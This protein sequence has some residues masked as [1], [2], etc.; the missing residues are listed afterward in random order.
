MSNS[1]HHLPLEQRTVTRVH[2]GKLVTESLLDAITD[3]QALAARFGDPSRS[4]ADE[5][6]AER[7]AA[8]GE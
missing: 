6:I 8:R 7:R 4:L 2:E 3:L 5:L 1:T